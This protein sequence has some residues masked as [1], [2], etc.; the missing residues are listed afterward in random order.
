MNLLTKTVTALICMFIGALPVHA[1]SPGEV[2]DLHAVVLVATP[3]L[4]DAEYRQTVL[5]ATI[6][7][8]GGHVGIILNRP[9]QRSLGSLFPEHGPSKKVVEPVFFGGPFGITALT[10]AVHTEQSPGPGSIIMMPGVFL[11]VGV[12]TIDKII[13]ERP[14]DAR[15]Y[16]GH[17]GWRPGELRQ[18]IR[19]GLWYVMPPDPEVVFRKDM[20]GLWEELVREARQVSAVLDPAFAPF[21]LNGL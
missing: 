19:R 17:V 1:Q 13:E 16:I 15:Y 21:T 3:A 12:Q 4:V 10:A 20:D 9:T 2:K 7:E 5:L 6:T 14:N 8:G 11:A 18:E